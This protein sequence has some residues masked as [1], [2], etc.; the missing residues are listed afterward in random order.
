MHTDTHVCVQTRSSTRT[1]VLAIRH[2]HTQAKTPR[3]HLSLSLPALVVFYEAM[4]FTRRR[5]CMSLEGSR[6]CA[7]VR[8]CVYACAHVCSYLSF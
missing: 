7:C 4:L 3:P 8:A 1:R 6:V 5:C 2:P